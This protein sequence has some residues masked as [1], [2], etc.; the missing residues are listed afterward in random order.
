MMGVLTKS[1]PRMTAV[2][3]DGFK[4]EPENMAHQKME[5][6]IIRHPEAAESH[7]VFGHNID[8]D[9]RLA[10]DPDNVGYRV[11][12]TVPDAALPFDD[13]TRV[14]TIE[15]GTFVVTGIEGSFEDD[16]SGSWITEGWNRLQ[17][18]VKRN[19]L[20]THPSHRWFE[21]LL[22]PAEPGNTRFDLYVEL[23]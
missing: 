18:M 12:L 21:E 8:A 11:M 9:G 5:A 23:K 3:F 2:V 15:A 10:H 1:L 20:E 4:P 19:D 22:E 16:P 17:E 14:E 13:E 7:R 6:W